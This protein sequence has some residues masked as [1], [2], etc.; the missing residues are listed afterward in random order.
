LE[1]KE[2]LQRVNIY[3]CLKG[4][5]TMGKTILIVLPIVILCL[6]FFVGSDAIREDNPP[7]ERNRP[8]LSIKETFDIYVRSVQNSDLEALFTTVTEE[9]KFFFLTTTG[10]LISSRTDYYTFHQDWF[11][12]DDWEM[13]V[14]YLEDHEGQ[15]YGYAT[16]LFHYKEKRPDGGAVFIDSYFTLIFHRED[17]MWKVVADICTPIDRSYSDPNSDSRYSSKQNFLFETIKN[18]RTVRRFKPAPV[19]KEHILKI[20]D[21]ARFAPTAGNQQPWKFLV[22]QDRKKLDDLRKHA[23]SWYLKRY[24]QRIKS[25]QEEKTKIEQA[26]K[27]RLDNV[28]S[29]PV[30]I[31]VLVDDKTRYADYALQDGVL[32]AGQLMIAARSLG[33]GTGFFTTFFAEKEMKEFFKI[34][35]RYKLICFT[36]IGIPHEWPETPEKKKLED[37]VVFDSF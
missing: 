29:A 20:L 36:P 34:P 32:A 3:D 25:N 6:L 17:N 9:K 31:A 19:P 22:I 35:D 8:G 10:V 12:E 23:F 21:A 30:Y 5:L 4:G 7:Q 37:L 15:E 1:R 18:R 16:A 27:E 13:P 14:E 2:K 26:L 33:Y 11:K 28:L 24:P